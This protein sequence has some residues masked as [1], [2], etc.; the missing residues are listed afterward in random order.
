[1]PRIP[2]QRAQGENVNFPA[3]GETILDL[4]VVPRG[5]DAQITVLGGN[6]E[7]EN[8]CLNGVGENKNA[9][10][11]E[12]GPELTPGVNSHFPWQLWRHKRPDLSPPGMP[13]ASP[14]M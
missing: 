10:G 7:N 6:E 12:G 3:V 9:N 5:E 1:M 4:V 11:L 8:M 13:K 14:K 2:P